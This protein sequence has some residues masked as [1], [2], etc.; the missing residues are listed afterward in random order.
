MHLKIS[1]AKWRPF[2]PGGEEL[3]HVVH[4]K[5]V[6][7]AFMNF[8]KTNLTNTTVHLSHIPQCTIQNRNVHF[9]SEWCIV[10]YGTGA[11][12]DLWICSIA[13]ALLFSFTCIHH[14]IYVFCMWN[15]VINQLC[16]D[17]SSLLVWNLT[18]LVL[19]FEIAT[20]TLWLLAHCIV[21]SSK[22][23]YWL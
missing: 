20:I 4:Y 23:W 19:K 1:S 13:S 15:K 3:V 9:C 2:C 8:K 7:F 12:W 18:P 21:R 11:L 14:F 5:I 22:P 17:L 10:G 6:N 16:L